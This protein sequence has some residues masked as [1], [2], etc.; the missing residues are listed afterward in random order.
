MRCDACGQDYEEIH[1][2]AGVPTTITREDGDRSSS[3][4]GLLYYLRLAIDI[5][6]WDR[7]AMRR[8][9]HDSK[10]AA[11]GA[12]LW[13][14]IAIPT[15]I[16]ATRA[17]VTRVWNIATPETP[18][19]TLSLIFAAGFIFGV[20][21]MAVLMLVQI[22]L[23]HFLCKWFLH[24][25]GTLKGV[26]RPRLLGSIVNALGMIPVIGDW[27]Y[28]IAWTAVMILVFEE[29]DGVGRLHAL[30]I[31]LVINAF[32]HELLGRIFGS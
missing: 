27:A 23:C 9:S 12:V 16:F 24:A 8:A 13:L 11:Y 32:S 17:W 20:A 25:T 4:S 28:G 6:S 3:G 14:I 15:E 30:V 18:K 29:V 21:A 5:A 31:C 7:V 19:T 2:C 1:D 22:G 10:A 26:L